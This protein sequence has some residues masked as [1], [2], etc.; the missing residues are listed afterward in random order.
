LAKLTAANACEPMKLI[1]IPAI[2]QVLFSTEW[3]IIMF[4]CGLQKVVE[5]RPDL[6]SLVVKHRFREEVA[7]ISSFFYPRSARIVLF[8]W[9]FEQEIGIV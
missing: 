7:D 5:D 8:F 4:T 2:K 9:H 1:A 6:K 3:A